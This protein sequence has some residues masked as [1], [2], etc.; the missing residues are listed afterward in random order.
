M[1]RYPQSYDVDYERTK[2]Y[3]KYIL[4][5]FFRWLKEKGIY[6]NWTKDCITMFHRIQMYNSMNRKNLDI[7][8]T[9]QLLRMCIVQ[10]RDNKTV[11]ISYLIKLAYPYIYYNSAVNRA[12]E[13][14]NLSD[15]EEYVIKPEELRKYIMEWFDYSY[16]IEKE[17][18]K[19]NGKVR[20]G[21]NIIS[22]I[23]YY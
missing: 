18:F 13:W 20:L 12:Y 9:N 10:S 23:D 21:E 3:V 7:S 5:I 16:Y 1:I 6:Y 17:Y 19:K 8:L 4:P 15:L 2:K 22:T 11:Q 14:I